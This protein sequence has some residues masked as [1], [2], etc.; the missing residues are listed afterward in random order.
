MGETVKANGATL[1]IQVDLFFRKEMGDSAA[2]TKTRKHR[3]PGLI[4]AL[5]IIQYEVIFP[6]V[7]KWDAYKAMKVITVRFGWCVIGKKP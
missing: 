3:K 1:L 6:V 2:G 4:T 5:H 7:K